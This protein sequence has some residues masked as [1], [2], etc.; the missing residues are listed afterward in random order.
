MIDTYKLRAA[1]MTEK[2][3]RD[4][5]L[6]TLEIFVERCLGVEVE[7]RRDLLDAAVAVAKGVLGAQDHRR[8][9]DGV[10]GAVRDL[11]HGER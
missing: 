3:Y 10:D 5:L 11:P 1:R 2:D 6:E 8:V 7:V 9:D 4:E